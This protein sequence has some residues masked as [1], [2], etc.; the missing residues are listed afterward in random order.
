MGLNIMKIQK[1]L[2]D[3]S[4]GIL[5]NYSEN[6]VE[7]ESC[8]ESQLLT[9]QYLAAVMLAN[10]GDRILLTSHF[11]KDDAK[12]ILKGKGS[13]LSSSLCLDFFKEYLNI[14]GSKV[15]NGIMELQGDCDMSLPFIAPAYQSK[16]IINSASY[17]KRLT[18]GLRFS[19]LRIAFS[20]AFRVEGEDYLDDLSSLLSTSTLKADDVFL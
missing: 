9:Y 5:K 1:S 11:W 2:E 12:S 16:L 18:W 13:D 14:Y 4:V 15:K 8:D 6:C 10:Q 3:L 20:A 17:H 7:V 19:G